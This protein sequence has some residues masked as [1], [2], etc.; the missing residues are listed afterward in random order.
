MQG[1]S[2]WEL[3]KEHLQ[4]P[5]Y[6]HVLLNPLPI[7]GLAIGLLACVLALFMRG[8]GAS[9]VAL[10]IVFVSALS[11]WPVAELGEQGFDRVLSMADETGDIWLKVHEARAH[12]VLWVFY[13]LAALSAISIF[14]PKKWPKSAKPLLAATTLITVAAL[15]CGGWVGYAGGQIRHKEFRYGP[16]PPAPPERDRD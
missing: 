7:Y 11:A 13:T 9:I 16:P 1:L 4:Q 3:L 2:G 15:A 6:L 8:R 14:A 10:T 5:E 12:E